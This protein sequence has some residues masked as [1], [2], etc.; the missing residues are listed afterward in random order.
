MSDATHGGSPPHGADKDTAPEDP[1]QRS[2]RVVPGDPAAMLDGLVEEF[3]RMGMPRDRI[4]NLFENPVFEATH[5]LSVV[6]GAE[7][8]HERVDAVLQRC[9]IWNITVHEVAAAQPC[10]ASG[11]PEQ[12]SDRGARGRP[13]HA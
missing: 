12:D 4:L 8:V 1:M 3:A 13:D 5:G 6:L 7:V 9:G 2:G 11:D 10:G